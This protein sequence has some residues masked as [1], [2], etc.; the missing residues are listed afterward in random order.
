MRKL[1]KLK[2]TIAGALIAALVFGMAVPAM[3]ALVRS[4]VEVYTGLNIVIDGTRFEPRDARGNRVTPFIY[5]GTTYLPV[6]AI[7]EAFGVLVH[8]DDATNSVFLD[9]HDD[10]N[11]GYIGC[12]DYGCDGCDYCDAD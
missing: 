7:G 4:T 12:F 5:N 9:S 11:S 6:R 2:Y 1:E 10:G 8:W 3:A